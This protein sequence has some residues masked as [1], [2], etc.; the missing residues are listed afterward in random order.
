MS[1]IGSPCATGVAL[2]RSLSFSFWRHWPGDAVSCNEQG[3]T[4]EAVIR[5]HW[6]CRLLAQGCQRARRAIYQTAVVR[7]LCAAG[8][9]RLPPESAEVDVRDIGRRRAGGCC[10]CR[11]RC[12][13]GSCDRGWRWTDSASLPCSATEVV[14][15]RPGRGSPCSLSQRAGL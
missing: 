4:G 12:L 9:G 3:T 6:F 15:L 1:V 8:G 10:R 11:G 2:W 5:A 13:T 7:H 14:C